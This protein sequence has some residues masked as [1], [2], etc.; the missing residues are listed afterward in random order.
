MLAQPSH[1]SITVGWSQS[2]SIHDG[3]AVGSLLE[4]FPLSHQ[5][6]TQPTQTEL[7]SR[8]PDSSSEPRCVLAR[9]QSP[10]AASSI[11]KALAPSSPLPRGAAHDLTWP[12][13]PKKYYRGCFSAGWQAEGGRERASFIMRRQVLLAEAE[14][15]LFF[16]LTWACSV[17]QMNVERGIRRSHIFSA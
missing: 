3:T 7:V 12:N 14:G 9:H 2:L 16:W 17:S 1:G 15:A 8:F 11:S 10:R 5:T 4:P 13:G 6:G